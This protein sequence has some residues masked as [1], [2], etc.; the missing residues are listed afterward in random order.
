[1]LTFLLQILANLDISEANVLANWQTCSLSES[2]A[3]GGYFAQI[4]LLVAYE[5][6]KNFYSGRLKTRKNVKKC[7][8]KI[9]KKNYNGR[10]RSYFSFIQEY[11]PLSVATTKAS[12]T[13]PSKSICGLTWQTLQ[14]P[15]QMR[16]ESQILFILTMEVTI[17]S[18][19]PLQNLASTTFLPIPVF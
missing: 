7:C 8:K 19:I 10:P 12:E 2:A 3:R 5:V 14:E 16:P 9:K 18:P 15:I 6:F 17:L 4:L 11:P 13:F 1:M